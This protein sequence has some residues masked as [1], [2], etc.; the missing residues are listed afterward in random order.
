MM[1]DHHDPDVG[2]EGV[3]TINAHGVRQQDKIVA[4]HYYGIDACHVSKADGVDNV[5]Y[6][7]YVHIDDD[8]EKHGD[9]PP[10]HWLQW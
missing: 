4:L 10:D 3:H 2:A 9:G 6:A 1:K 7:E 8:N 5:Q